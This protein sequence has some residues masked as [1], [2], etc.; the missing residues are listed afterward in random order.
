MP[1]DQSPRVE[2]SADAPL[3][4]ATL[5]PMP[6]HPPKLRGAVV[7][8]CLT[9]YGLT[10]L[11]ARIVASA[12]QDTAASVELRH[13]SPRPPGVRNRQRVF[14]IPLAGLRPNHSLR[15]VRAGARSRLSAAS[16][17]R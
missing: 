4:R 13:P 10:Q 16:A 17:Q 5:S 11:A 2:A 6:S 9:G 7:I 12:W 3:P 15:L 8:Q 14:D 1:R